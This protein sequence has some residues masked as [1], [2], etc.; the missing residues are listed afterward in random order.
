MTAAVLTAAV[1]QT[2]PSVVSTMTFMFMA[3]TSGIG[4]LMAVYAVYLMR[5]YRHGWLPCTALLVCVLGTYQTYISF[6]ITLMLLGM[7][8][9]IFRGRH[10]RAY[11]G[12]GSCVSWYSAR[13]CS[14]I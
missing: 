13:V 6:A 4:I 10:S 1:L 5:K 3:H 12:E 2:F 11:S 8:A 9:D 7:I 14:S